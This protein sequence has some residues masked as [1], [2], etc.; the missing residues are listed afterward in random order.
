[1]KPLE[2]LDNKYTKTFTALGVVSGIGYSIFKKTGFLKGA[3]FYL[4]FGVAGS[5][6][7]T[8]INEIVKKDK[9]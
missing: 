4:L 9:K 7:G 1:M 3:G 6:I 5:L 2:I 8:G